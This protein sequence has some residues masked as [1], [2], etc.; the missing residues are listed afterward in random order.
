MVLE[1]D[2]RR[3]Q[4]VRVRTAAQTEVSGSVSI[5]GRRCDRQLDSVALN[6]FLQELTSLGDF[7]GGGGSYPLEGNL[8]YSGLEG[9][10]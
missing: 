6:S 8:R 1:T 10:A 4:E 3:W 5:D 7:V 2:P 9:E